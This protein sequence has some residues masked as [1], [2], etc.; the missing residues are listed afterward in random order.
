MGQ[1]RQGAG[2]PVWGEEGLTACYMLS[3][4]LIPRKGK[5]FQQSLNLTLA[6]LKPFSRLQFHTRKIQNMQ[7]FHPRLNPDIS[8]FYLQSSR[9]R[10]RGAHRTAGQAPQGSLD[11]SSYPSSQALSNLLLAPFPSNLCSLPLKSHM[12]SLKLFYRLKNYLCP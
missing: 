12:R 1:E 9:E 8:H 2:H 7:I 3:L 11:W 4:L 5:G 6:F 10:V